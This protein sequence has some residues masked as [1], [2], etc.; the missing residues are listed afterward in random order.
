M[1]AHSNSICIL[2]DN[3]LVRNSIVQL[4]DSDGLQAES[5]EDTEVFFAHLN[6]NKVSLAVIDL[7]MPNMNGLE[8]Q[9]RLRKISPDTEVIVITGREIP[10]VRLAAL[11][12]GALAFLVKP[13]DDEVFL[14]LVRHALRISR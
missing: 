3:V 5:F 13:F 7:W 1:P 14:S 11:E 8:V 2:D 4:L 9:A 12:G 10:G 6:R